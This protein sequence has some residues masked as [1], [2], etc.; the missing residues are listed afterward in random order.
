MPI[1]IQTYT[2]SLV[3]GVRAFNKRV[4]GA[5][6][7]SFGFPESPIP[8]W[9]A[10]V[11]GD[12]ARSDL[13]YQEMFV[14][15]DDA[16]VVRGGYVLKHQSFAFA[17]A[18][19]SVGFYRAPLSEGIAD[20]RFATL[21]A[22]MLRDA[23][24]RQPLLF[25][26]GLGGREQALT[27]ML[28]V[29]RWNIAEVPFY[30]RIARGGRVF[31]ELRAIRTSALRRIAMN[32]VAWSGAGWL[33]PPVL[34]GSA[35]RVPPDVSVVEAWPSQPDM[36][37]LFHLESKA[38]S[39]CAVRTRAVLDRLYEPP[40]PHRAVI[41]VVGPANALAG[42]AVVLN[43]PMH[44]DKYFGD[45]RLGS[46]IDVW[47]RAGREASVISAAV[48]YLQE[49]E[50]ELIISNQSHHRWCSAMRDNGF[51][52]GPSNFLFAA[53]PALWTLLGGQD[54]LDRVH[55]LRADGDGP[56]HL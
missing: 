10:P 48:A 44:D 38:F 50:A 3:P 41:G 40:N 13:P 42:W 34:H 11:G 49:R 43:T 51:R 21:G 37:E 27:R 16:G 6:P 52:Q 30:Y 22:Q 18:I 35:P 4:A 28:Q 12:S 19:R 25:A 24:R 9:L 20:R 1:A 29:M 32:A 2:D 17:G 23:I 53:A 5:D 36:D 14:A 7:S 15:T 31:R 8:H 54:A 33:A 56:I 47:A 39:F 55:L 26:L 46:I 45:L